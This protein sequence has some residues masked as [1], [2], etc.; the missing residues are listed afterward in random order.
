MTSGC[1]CALKVTCTNENKVAPVYPDDN[2]VPGR[3]QR[4]L[5]AI[6]CP[7]GTR[8]LGWHQPNVTC[9]PGTS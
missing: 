7:V 6:G 1:N 5:E 4:A 2:K 9:H 8:E 3:H